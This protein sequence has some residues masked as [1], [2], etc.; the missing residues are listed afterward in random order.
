MWTQLWK[1]C[2]LLLT[3]ALALPAMAIEEPAFDVVY[4]EGAYQI[5]RYTN[6]LVAEVFVDGDMDDASNQGFRL[7][8][9]FIFGNNQASTA[10]S[11]KIAMTAP[12]IVAPVS[13][14]TAKPSSEKIA[15]TAPVTV[16]KVDGMPSANRWRV[17]FVMPRSY[18]LQT[19]PLPKNPRVQIREVPGKTYAVLT[20]SGF[21]GQ[22]KINKQTQDLLAWAQVQKKTVLGAPQLARYDPPW[23]LPMW[24]RNEVMVEIGTP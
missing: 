19:L 3:L 10:K 1:W 4:S 7:I 5:R 20:Y 21:N 18:T 16:E 14:D 12:V 22:A 17:Q 2:S 23:T 9:D 8:A 15:M 13:A 24:R 11:E 6:T